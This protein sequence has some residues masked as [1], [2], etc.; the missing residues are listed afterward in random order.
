MHASR[1]EMRAAA[2]TLDLAPD[3]RPDE[4]FLSSHSH[5]TVCSGAAAR[6]NAARLIL[7]L[8]STYC[9]HPGLREPLWD[10]GVASSFT[11]C[12]SQ[13]AVCCMCV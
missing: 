8:V 10:G 5:S 9:Y 11:F 6:A 7:R 12:A 1:D 2:A 13:S 3:P 4:T